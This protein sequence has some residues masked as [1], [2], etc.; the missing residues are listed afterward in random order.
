MLVVF[1]FGSC[2]PSLSQTIDTSLG[3]ALTSQLMLTAFPSQVY[4]ATAPCILGASSEKCMVST[5]DVYN[6]S[7]VKMNLWALRDQEML[8]VNPPGHTHDIRQREL[9]T[10]DLQVGRLIILPDGTASRALVLTSVRILDILQREGGHA[11][12]TPH[13]HISIQTLNESRKWVMVSETSVPFH[14]RSTLLSTEDISS[15]RCVTWKKS[16]TSRTD[17]TLMKPA[18][19]AL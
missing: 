17:I 3:C 11:R 16:L 10:A 4:T 6:S 8:N 2:S 15:L 9:L 18:H 7:P 12:V 1:E 13:H 19:S 5:K 14:S